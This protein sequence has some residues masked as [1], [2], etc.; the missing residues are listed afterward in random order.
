MGIDRPIIREQQVPYR[1]NQV[2]F[3]REMDAWFPFKKLDA[4]LH[5]LTSDFQKE[6]HHPAQDLLP[7]E[8]IPGG[9]SLEQMM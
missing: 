3:L 2:L 8:W 5:I 4:W 6:N 7:L 9:P 1:G